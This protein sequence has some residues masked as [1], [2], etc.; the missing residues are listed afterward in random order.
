MVALVLDVASAVW[1]NTNS[2]LA[3]SFGGGQPVATLAAG[4]D[5]WLLGMLFWL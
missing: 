4:Y 5:C 3:D 1:I 2:G